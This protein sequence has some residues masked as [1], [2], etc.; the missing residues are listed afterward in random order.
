MFMREIAELLAQKEAE[1]SNLTR[2]L[3]TISKE[4]DALKTTIRLLE[5]AGAT[6]STG[7]DNVKRPAAS[8]K[9]D[10]TH[11]VSRESAVAELP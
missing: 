6:K 5:Q 11:G 10:N 2:Q 8:V 4:L 9:S 1:F 7:F 3:E